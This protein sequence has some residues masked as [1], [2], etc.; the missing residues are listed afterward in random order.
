MYN[1]FVMHDHWQRLHIIMYKSF[2][3][4]KEES[5]DNRHLYIYGLLCYIFSHLF[6]VIFMCFWFSCIYIALKKRVYLYMFYSVLKKRWNIKMHEIHHK[7]EDTVKHRQWKICGTWWYRKY[8]QWKISG[9]T[10]RHRH[11]CRSHPSHGTVGATG[12]TISSPLNFCNNFL[13]GKLKYYTREHLCKILP[14]WPP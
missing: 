3:M 1:E 4:D 6:K 8:K 12:N 7:H 10:Q 2:M 13:C 9:T 14:T 11:W 5:G